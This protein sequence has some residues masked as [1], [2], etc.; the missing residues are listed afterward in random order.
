[1]AAHR[2]ELPDR[3]N[4]LAPC[5]VGDW[6]VYPDQG[7]LTG[8]GGEVRVEP[9]AMHMLACLAARPGELVTHQDLL[10]TVWHDAV[11]NEGALSRTVSE[12]RRFLGDDA[13]S[14]RYIETIYKRGYRLLA[15]VAPL[16]ERGPRRD[17]RRAAIMTVACLGLILVAV[18]IVRFRPAPAPAASAPEFLAGRPL[19]STPGLET[20]PAL[21]PDGSLVAFC[22]RDEGRTDEDIHLKPTD[23][24]P[25]RPFV[26]SDR[27]EMKPVFSPDGATLAYMRLDEDLQL[28]VQDLDAEESRVLAEFPQWVWGLDWAPDGEHLVVATAPEHG[29][30]VRLVEVALADGSRR[31]LTSPGPAV[32]DHLPRYAFDGRLA[33]VRMGGRNGGHVCL[34]EE[35]HVRRL[36]TEARYVSGLDWTADGRGLVV[37]RGGA[38]GLEL[39][40]LDVADG[41]HSVLPVRSGEPWAPALAA[42]SLVYEES[43]VDVDIAGMG[44][45]PAA[46]P[47]RAE[48][49]ARAALVST[50]LDYSASFSPDGSRIAFASERGGTRQIWLCNQDGGQVRQLTRFSGRG[51]EQVRWAPDGRRLACVIS[52]AR[53]LGA[54]VVESGDGSH[55]VV[56]TRGGQFQGWSRTGDAVYVVRGEGADSGLWRLPLDGGEPDLVVQ[57]AHGFVGEEADGAVLYR[58]WNGKDIRRRGPDEGSDT[59]AFAGEDLGDWISADPLGDRLHVTCIDG[60]G[61]LLV[62]H[63]PVTA[64]ADTLARLPRGWGRELSVSPDGSEFLHHGICRSERDLILVRDFCP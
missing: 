29:A 12:L 55:R 39:H 13:R 47:P 5:R 27:R 2:S 32:G 7:R 30:P 9:R 6:D 23:G 42:G 22:R 4:D 63:D 38:T 46:N 43:V 25:S 45:V 49:R 31:P 18:G 58:L 40:L 54:A 16:P 61:V 20:A 34:V 33:C 57:E 59:V 51:L 24:G 44:L 41:S 17:F 15:A 35:G 56:E 3:V 10:A 11:V 60:D 26:N 48:P 21:S 28:V 19:T 64:R 37:S 14:P 36:T 50:R 53:G 8:P 52:T 62:R 1:M